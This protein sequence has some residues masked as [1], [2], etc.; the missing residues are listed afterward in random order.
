MV[1]VRPLSALFAPVAPTS[2]MLDPEPPSVTLALLVEICPLLNS[3][4]A[5]LL[6]LIVPVSVPAVPVPAA[7][8]MSTVPVTVADP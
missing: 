7:E 4:T 1:E 3:S 2:L 6:R 8:P 5:S